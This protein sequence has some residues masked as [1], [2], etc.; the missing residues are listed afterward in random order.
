M[1]AV[2]NNLRYRGVESIN[3]L[4]YSVY[5]LIVP[6]HSD[7]YSKPQIDLTKYLLQTPGDTVRRHDYRELEFISLIMSSGQNFH[8]QALSWRIIIFFLNFVRHCD[9]RNE[10]GYFLPTLWFDS[11]L[12]KSETIA[13]GDAPLGCY[14]ATTEQ[15]RSSFGRS[16][17]QL[18][19]GNVEWYYG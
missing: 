16:L 18:T 7:Q 19:V 11:T 5:R 14:S 2:A 10:Q 13:Q 3:L 8:V 6:S 17:Y 9:T 12:G 15:R 1:S 4:V